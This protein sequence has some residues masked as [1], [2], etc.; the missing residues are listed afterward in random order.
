MLRRYSYI[1][2]KKVTR[3]GYISTTESEYAALSQSLRDALPM[4]KVLEELA[5]ALGFAKPEIVMRC[6]VYEDNSGA[7]AL[8][9]DHKY[10]PRKKQIAVKYHHFRERVSKGEVTVLKISTHLQKADILTKSLE[11]TAFSRLRILVMGW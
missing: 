1:L 8:A 5:G 7:V 10:R 6:N 3:R 2:A 11:A 4:Q 9:S